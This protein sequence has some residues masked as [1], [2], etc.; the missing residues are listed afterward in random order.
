MGLSGVVLAATVV[1]AAL[2]GVAGAVSV[3]VEVG[4]VAVVASWLPLQPQATTA[5]AKKVA[6][7]M[8]KRM[9]RIILCRLSR[10]Q[11]NGLDN[12]QLHARIAV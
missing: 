1:V 10:A 9:E 6:E 7:R 3:L 8:A 2:V 11:K 5:R 12:P 4:V